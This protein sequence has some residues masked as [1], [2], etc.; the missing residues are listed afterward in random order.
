ML[1]KD[2]SLCSVGQVLRITESSLA[3]VACLDDDTNQCERS[4]FCKTL[5]MWTGLNKVITDYLDGISLQNLLEQAQEQG[6]DNYM[7]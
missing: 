5:P 3:P 2:P 7:I 1:A 4:G 6:A